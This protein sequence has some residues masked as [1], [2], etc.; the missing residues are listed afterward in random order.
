MALFWCL[1]ALVL[2]SLA[3][4][5]VL[6]SL[7]GPQEPPSLPAL[8]VI[9]SLLSLRSPQPPHVLFMELQDKYGPTYSLKMGSHRVIMVNHHVHAKEVLLKKGKTFA[10]RPQTVSI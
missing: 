2:V 9:G 10:G 8:P 5:S 4:L 6:T 1:C 7:R 3:L